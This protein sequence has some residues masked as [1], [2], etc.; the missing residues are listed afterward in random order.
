MGII[1]PFLRNYIKAQVISAFLESA[2]F[3]GQGTVYLRQRPFSYTV[4]DGVARRG[5]TKRGTPFAVVMCKC[6]PSVATSSGTSGRVRR[7]DASGLTPKTTGASCSRP[8][9]RRRGPRDCGWIPDSGEFPF[10]THGP[11]SRQTDGLR[12]CAEGLRCASTSLRGCSCCRITCSAWWR[13]LRVC[14]CVYMHARCVC[15][16]GSRRV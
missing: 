11:A 15:P 4:M 13:A 12:E 10:Q 5:L 14:V 1:I 16:C 7:P 3:G 9:W 2:Y 8:T 6:T